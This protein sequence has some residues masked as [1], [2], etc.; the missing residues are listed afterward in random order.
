MEKNLYTYG[1]RWSTTYLHGT[2]I[3]MLEISN[4]RGE[5]VPETKCCPHRLLARYV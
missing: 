4:G 1:E 5:S 2:K 3:R